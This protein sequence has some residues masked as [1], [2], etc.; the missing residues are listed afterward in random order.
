MAQP[1]PVYHRTPLPPEARYRVGWLV[2]CWLAII[3]SPFVGFALHGQVSER[4]LV[5]GLCL[6]LL[7]GLG[8]MLLQ[9]QHRAR[10]RRVPPEVMHEW[11][12]GR[13]IP[14][15]GAPSVAPPLRQASKRHWIE[16]R[17]DGVLM[18]R[19]AL[20]TLDGTDG[21][22]EHIASLRTADTAGQYFVPWTA[23]DTW[24]V[25]TDSDGPDFHRLR[26]R[27]RGALHIRRFRPHT[28]HEADLLDGVRSIGRV[29][30]RLHD[31]LMAS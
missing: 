31:D 2:L 17:A 18:S 12:H 30:V 16:L 23:I 6:A 22:Q 5:M 11:R 29:P 20:L 14:P 25:T 13:P 15:E 21:F 27:P 19:S 4:G 7:P 3:F 28:G 8:L 9:R 10:L 1:H 26:L 24:E